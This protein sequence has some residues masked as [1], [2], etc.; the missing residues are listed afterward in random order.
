MQYKSKINVLRISRQS[1]GQGGWTKLSAILHENVP[2]RINWKKGIEKIFFDKNSY[3]R[4]AVIYCRVI[5]VTNEDMIEY[6][7]T[8]YEI[9]D[10]AN[11]DEVNRYMVITMRK[12]GGVT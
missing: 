10:V 9:V 3:F 8:K 2:C 1:D 11:P 5:D 12:V 6:N 7:G 4:D